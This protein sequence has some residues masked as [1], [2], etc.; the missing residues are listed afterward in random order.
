MQQGPVFV[1]QK[2][3]VNAIS[4]IL[5]GIGILSASLIYYDRVTSDVP[6]SLKIDSKEAKR[7]AFAEGNWNDSLL[8]DKSVKSSL[9]HIKNDGFAFLVDPQSLAD[10][11]LHMTKFSKLEPEQYVWHITIQNKNNR[12]W[13]YLIDAKRGDIIQSPNQTFEKLKPV[14]PYESIDNNSVITQAKGDVAIEFSNGITES[15]SN[16]FP[17]KLVITAGDTVTWKNDDKQVHSVADIS[18]DNHSDVGRIIDS[19]II[20]SGESFSFTFEQKHIGQIGYAC[21]IHPWEAGTV[22]VQENN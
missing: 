21:L 22:T 16:P 13:N 9:L 8:E 10:K 5:V 17:A 3:H 12:E 19:G 20:G 4:I 6:V 18:A 7:L 11:E 14:N 2:K 15:K 1:V